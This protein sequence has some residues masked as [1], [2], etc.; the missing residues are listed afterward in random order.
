MFPSSMLSGLFVKGSLQNT[1]S[2]FGLRLR[3]NIDSGTITGLGPLGVDDTTIS[4][5]KIILKVGQ[6][7]V[8]GDQLS[9][10][11]PLPV[12]VMSEIKVEVEGEP[13]SPGQHKISFQIMTAEAGRLNFSI[14]E[15]VVE[16]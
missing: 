15:T 9:Y 1:P 13:L 12:G 16:L 8:R 10:R 6:K 3:N 7:E 5:D 2:G 4:A 11:S 14:S